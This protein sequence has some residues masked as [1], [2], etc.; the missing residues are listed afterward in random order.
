[1][2]W[3]KICVILIS[4][5]KLICSVW[6]FGR[7]YFT[8]MGILPDQGLLFFLPAPGSPDNMATDSRLEFRPPSQPQPV[9]QLRPLD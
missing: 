8:S 3:R 5:S 1:M 6:E 7:L 2:R 4:E 9:W